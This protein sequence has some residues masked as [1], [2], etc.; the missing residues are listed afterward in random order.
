LRVRPRLR[1]I[2]DRVIARR[3]GGEPC[4]GVRL[5]VLLE[6]VGA[7]DGRGTTIDFPL[8]PDA[9]GDVHLAAFDR[10]VDEAAADFE[11]TWVLVSAGFDAHRSCPITSLGL[12]AGDYADRARRCAALA[13]PGGFV[14]FLE[15]GY[16]LDTLEDAAAADGRSS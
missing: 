13:P 4:P 6:E 12:S 9:T 8:P 2:T 16:D 15:G 1:H 5:R 10:V 14:A 11:A 3:G 7:G